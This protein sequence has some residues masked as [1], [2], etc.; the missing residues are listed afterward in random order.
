[1][2]IE[3]RIDHR[4]RLVQA[5][6]VGALTRDD[7]FNYQIE[8]WSHPEVAGYDELI[9]MTALESLVPSPSAQDMRELAALSAS[10]DSQAARARVVIVAPQALTF[11]LGRMYEAWRAAEP[12]GSKTVEVVRTLVEALE[13][14]GMSPQAPAK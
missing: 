9:D 1:M 6:A 7:I 13:F 11:G 4:R 3:V 10:M 8:T 12:T 5:T 2:P 14:L